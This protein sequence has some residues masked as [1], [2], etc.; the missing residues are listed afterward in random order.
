MLRRGFLLRRSLGVVPERR[1]LCSPEEQLPSSG[2]VMVPLG[3]DLISASPKAD[4]GT[5][6]I[7]ATAS[8]ARGK[9]FS[10][11]PAL[12]EAPTFSVHAKVSSGSKST[13]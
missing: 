2:S 8:V 12:E 11:P 1:R 4:A 10:F 9:P 5:L 13:L 6:V 3:M 7:S